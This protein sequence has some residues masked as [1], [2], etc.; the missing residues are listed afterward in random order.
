MFAI[1]KDMNLYV[2][3]HPHLVLGDLDLNSVIDVM[4]SMGVF[5]FGRKCLSKSYEEGSTGER[6][7]NIRNYSMLTV[8]LPCFVITKSKGKTMISATEYINYKQLL[9][10]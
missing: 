8:F 3:L 1:H 2:T 7:K 6:N 4:G 5:T 9:H 10:N